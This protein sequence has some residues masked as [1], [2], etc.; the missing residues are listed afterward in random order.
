MGVSK[1]VRYHGYLSSVSLR[2]QMD[3]SNTWIS[4]FTRQLDLELMFTSTI[5]L[6]TAN[7]NKWTKLFTDLLALSIGSTYSLALFIRFGG[8]AQWTYLLALFIGFIYSLALFIR[9][10]GFTRWTYLVALFVGFIYS[11]ALYI[12]SGGFISLPHLWTLVLAYTVFILLANSVS[13]SYISERNTFTFP[14]RYISHDLMEKI[15]PF[16]LRHHPCLI[17]LTLLQLHH[18]TLLIKLTNTISLHHTPYT[19]PLI[20]LTN[21][22]SLCNNCYTCS[23]SSLHCSN[24]I[25]PCSGS[26]RLLIPLGIQL[27][28][29][30]FIFIPFTQRSTSYSTSNYIWDTLKRR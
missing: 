25:S 28:H 12:R 30:P 2:L 15:F 21:I 4:W 9:F 19:C 13:F 27:L 6:R 18:H 8:F 5:S 26:T 16:A 23:I 10:G 22:T 17:K 20:K 3:Y 1:F 7:W 14:T 24:I 29:L 11:L